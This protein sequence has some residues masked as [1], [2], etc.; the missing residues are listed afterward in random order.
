[1][2]KW[3][4]LSGALADHPGTN[5][6]I[7]RSCMKVAPLTDPLRLLEVSKWPKQEGVLKARFANM[8]ILNIDL[9]AACSACYELCLLREDS[10]QTMGDCAQICEGKQY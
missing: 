6:M 8:D 3:M 4:Q 7:V 1:M 5:M 10:A 9:S 2:N